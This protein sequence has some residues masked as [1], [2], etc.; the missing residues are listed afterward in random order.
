[1]VSSHFLHVFQCIVVCASHPSYTWCPTA[2][3]EL[4]SG[5]TANTTFSPKDAEPH[6][7]AAQRTSARAECTL[8]R[9]GVGPRA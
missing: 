7:D 6:S 2:I 1:M 3:T 4:Y 5:T 9:Y 8:T